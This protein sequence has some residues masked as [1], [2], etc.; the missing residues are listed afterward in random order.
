[1]CSKRYPEEFRIGTVKQIIE[2]GIRWQGSLCRT[3]EGGPIRQGND[4]IVTVRA[5]MTDREGVHP[6]GRVRS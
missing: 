5:A 2:R 6:A 4:K 1:M 3:L